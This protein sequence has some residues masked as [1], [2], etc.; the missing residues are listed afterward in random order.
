M[1]NGIRGSALVFG[2]VEL[3]PGKKIAIDIDHDSRLI[4]NGMISKQ[5]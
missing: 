3:W 4:C 5:A 1:F 2:V